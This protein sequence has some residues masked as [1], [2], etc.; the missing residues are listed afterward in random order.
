MYSEQ[1]ITGDHV[2]LTYVWGQGEMDIEMPLTLKA[3]VHT[4]EDGVELIDL[5]KLLPRTIGDAIEVTRS[6]GFTY[7]WV[8]SLCIIQDDREDRHN[9]INMM[10]E[11]Y[12][13]ATLTIA[14]GS[15]PHAN[16]GLP[17]I[18][19]PRSVDQQT[20]RIGPYEF[21]VGFPS[22]DEIN[23]NRNLKYL[24]WNTRV[25]I[26][27]ED[28]L[29]KITLIHR[30]SNVFQVWE[31]LLCRGRSNGNRTSLAQCLKAKSASI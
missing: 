19:I 28:S 16:W 2:T 9:Q 27:R 26:A 10:D 18:S 13:N 5:P 31:L 23:N 7:L 12:I 17:G 11:I 6:L 3:S 14:A 4:V 15:S 29:K 8:D 21:A 20:E 24:T 30:Y 25:D 1:H 22:F